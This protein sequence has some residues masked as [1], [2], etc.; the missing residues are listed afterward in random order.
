VNPTHKEP[1]MGKGK[2]EKLVFKRK[3]LLAESRKKHAE[4]LEISPFQVLITIPYETEVKS[5]KPL[6][7]A[8]EKIIDKEETRINDQVGDL[9]RK[10]AELQEKEQKGDSKA[11]AAAQTALKA[12]NGDVKELLGDLNTDV[13]EAV[14]DAINKSAR[15]F[16]NLQAVGSNS[17]KGIKIKKGVFTGAAN[18]EAIE[19]FGEAAD[20]LAEAGEALLKLAKHEGGLRS[21]LVKAIGD[22][23]DLVEQA[24]KTDGKADLKQLEKDNSKPF[25]ALESARK[26]YDDALSELEGD[27]NQAAKVLDD[28]KKLQRSEKD[29]A[30]TKKLV[31]AYSMSL[32]YLTWVLA[33]LS[34]AAAAA[35][36]SVAGDVKSARKTLA[37]LDKQP[38]AQRSAQ[39]LRDAGKKLSSAAGKL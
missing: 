15:K 6:L 12:V 28:L 8:G 38:D 11:A 27:A 37:N 31:E 19:D 35:A 32:D 14:E 23:L 13:R 9:A 1:A 25:R 33:D 18:V 4:L 34:M 22:C 20:A 39:A 21:D 17:C 30:E 29:L 7:D 24:A 16:E 2:A 36:D 3:D 26:Q 10:I 5:D